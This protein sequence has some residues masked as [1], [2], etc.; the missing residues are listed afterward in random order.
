MVN[1]KLR[2]L[3]KQA[4]LTQQQLADKLGISIRLL[5]KYE[6]GDVLLLNMSFGRAL[7]YAEALG[8]DIKDLL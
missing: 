3:R 4:G 8:V 1:T 6:R 7:S 5:Q 2:D